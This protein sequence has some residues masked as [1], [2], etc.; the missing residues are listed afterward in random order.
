MMW[1]LYEIPGT[2][3]NT[4]TSTYTHK[5]FTR[6]WSKFLVE[7]ILFSTITLDGALWTCG[8]VKGGLGYSVFSNQLDTFSRLVLVQSR[9]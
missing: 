6:Q 7:M 8:C 3:T 2:I 9:R 4:T 5:P 1:M